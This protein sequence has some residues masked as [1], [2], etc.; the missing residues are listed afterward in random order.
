[1]GLISSRNLPELYY[2]YSCN[3]DSPRFNGCNLNDINVLLALGPLANE[4][5]S[6]GNEL[7]DLNGDGVL[8]EG[9]VD[10][11]LAHAAQS[12]GFTFEDPYKRG[13][14]NLDGIVDVADLNIWNRHKFTNSLRWDQ[15]DFNA[16][17][18]V[19]IGDFNLWNQNKFTQLDPYDP[20]AVPEPSS[21]CILL[22]GLVLLGTLRMT[23]RS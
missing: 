21:C 16:D 7:F 2:G 14:A 15:G 10:N 9:D 3:L 23:R 19:D 8:S 6:D 22:G 1:M 4:V 18:V 17:G 11:W 5:P 20:F 12:N 13:D